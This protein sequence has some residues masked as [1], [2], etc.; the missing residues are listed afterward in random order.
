MDDDDESEKKLA[1]T[2]AC[3][4]QKWRWK[5]SLAFSHF[6]LDSRKAKNVHF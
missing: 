5:S 4:V 6:Q 2:F 1:E 3:K